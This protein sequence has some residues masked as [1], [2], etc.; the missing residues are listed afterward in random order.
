MWIVRQSLVPDPVL[1][2]Q[3]VRV[4]LSLLSFLCT[5]A[6]QLLVSFHVFFS[7]KVAVVVKAEPPEPKFVAHSQCS[8]IMSCSLLG[9]IGHIRE[10][11]IK[12]LHARLPS[13]DV[14]ED[15][16]QLLPQDTVVSIGL[17]SCVVL[18]LNQEQL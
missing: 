11:H 18:P 10:E 13:Q 1:A 7:R 12:L 15:V 9:V 16:W 2:L 5:R 17:Y 4:P 3:V 14:L 8:S 6:L